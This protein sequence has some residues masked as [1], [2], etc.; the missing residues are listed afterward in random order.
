[1]WY[2]WEEGQRS[3]N[4]ETWT[5]NAPDVIAGYDEWDYMGRTTLD[6]PRGFSKFQQMAVQELSNGTR[7]AWVNDF[8]HVRTG[9]AFYRDDADF[10]NMSLVGLCV[11]A[12]ESL[13]RGDCRVRDA[14]YNESDGHFYLML[15]G[16]GVIGIWYGA[17]VAESNDW[18]VSGDLDENPIY[19]ESD[20]EDGA[21]FDERVYSPRTL[22][23]SWTDS[24]CWGVV[25]GIANKEKPWDWDSDLVFSSASIRGINSSN[26]WGDTLSGSYGYFSYKT[27]FNNSSGGL[28]FKW[29]DNEVYFAVRDYAGDNMGLFSAMGFWAN[30]TVE[31][32]QGSVPEFRYSGAPTESEF[33][34]LYDFN[35]WV[36]KNPINVTVNQISGTALIYAKFS[37]EGTINDTIYVQISD[38]TPSTC[39]LHE[40]VDGSTFNFT[41]T[42]DPWG[43]VAKLKPLG[44]DDDFL[45]SRVLRVN[46]HTS[47]V[48]EIIVI[49]I[50]LLLLLI[51]S[52]KKIIQERKISN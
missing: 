35:I 2:R 44:T 11:K 7:L 22:W 20:W 29:P 15:G 46:T 52:I 1:V 21:H 16:S 28:V 33:K 17:Y 42:N 39:F 49:I 10:I 26:F 38:L 43:A 41:I 27:T 32:G 30:E 18:N 34:S 23:M 37:V 13:L 19:Q 8:N 36:W 50:V 40:T 47:R 3:D 25:S 12:P 51:Y 45:F 5:T 14:W 4:P 6:Y 31:I 48:F 9:V 24:K